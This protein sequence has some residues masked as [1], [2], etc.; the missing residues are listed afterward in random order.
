M[1]EGE[2]KPLVEG[3]AFIIEPTVHGARASEEI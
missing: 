1:S 2:M 3:F